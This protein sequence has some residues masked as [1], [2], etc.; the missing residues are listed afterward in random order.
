MQKQKNRSR[1]RK[2]KQ[3]KSKLQK[4]AFVLII[5]IL[6]IILGINISDRLTTDH[7]KTEYSAVDPQDNSYQTVVIK[8]GSTVQDMA[9]DLHDAGLVRSE[10]YFSK[11]ALGKGG[12]GLQAGTYYLKKSQSM[13]EIYA[14][15]VKGPNIDVYRKLFIE[16]RASYAKELQTKYK[17]LASI[18]LAQT[19]LESEW[20]TSTLA[21]K[22]NNYYGIKAQGKQ[23]SVQLDT[24]E[25]LN[26]KW[27]TEKDKFA[28]YSDWRT[29]MLAHAKFIANGTALNSAQFKDVLSA[30]DYKKA[31][32]ALVTDGYATDPDYANKII[33]I[34]ETYKLNQYDN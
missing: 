23:K 11:F 8:S 34:I 10:L 3:K 18:N 27:V 2:R 31:A 19:I 6:I 33:T 30:G 13:S 1:S 7:L 32:A 24:K 5:F 16:K 28:V 26:G 14:Q 15:L 21:S 17:V 29:G 22:Y 20:G 9:K 25:Y 4:I 12:S